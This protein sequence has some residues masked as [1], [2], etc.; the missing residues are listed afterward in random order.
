MGLILTAVEGRGM[1]NC[2]IEKVSAAFADA[3]RP[4]RATFREP[5]TPR[6]KYSLAAR[7]YMH[8]LRLAAL[9]EEAGRPTRKARSVEEI[10]KLQLLPR[11]REDRTAVTLMS[12][13]STGLRLLQVV[14][15]QT[16][17]T[18]LLVESIEQDSLAYK[19]GVRRG[20]LLRTVQGRCVVGLQPDR[21]LFLPLDERPLVMEFVEGKHGLVGDARY[22][23]Y[24]NRLRAEA[25]AKQTQNAVRAHIQQ[26]SRLRRPKPA[27]AEAVPDRSTGPL[28]FNRHKSPY[29]DATVRNTAM[30]WAEAFSDEAT[31]RQAT[32]KAPVYQKLSADKRAALIVPAQLEGP[33]TIGMCVPRPLLP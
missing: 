26:K 5:H 28:R 12:R 8:T 13:G 14:M 17:Q 30:R 32:V 10:E 21:L 3:G 22:S 9:E 1:R 6:G 33:P 31:R 27:P 19:Q 16:G 20:M 11:D 18:W 24:E 15:Q 25:D 7:F 4:V 2:S 23:A 29:N